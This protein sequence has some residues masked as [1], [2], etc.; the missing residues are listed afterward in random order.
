MQL[1]NNLILLSS[2]KFPLQ[3]NKIKYPDGEGQELNEAEDVSG[4]FPP[5]FWLHLSLSHSLC[6]KKGV[7]LRGLSRVFTCFYA[8]PSMCLQHKIMSKSYVGYLVAQMD[9]WELNILYRNSPPSVCKLLCFISRTNRKDLTT[10]WDCQGKELKQKPSL[11]RKMS[12]PGDKEG[13]TKPLLSPIIQR[14]GWTSLC[15]VFRQTER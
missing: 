4:L 10:V 3:L 15:P 1:Y 14:P 2:N 6:G 11:E 5:S 12:L 7:F 13:V 8:N 9:S